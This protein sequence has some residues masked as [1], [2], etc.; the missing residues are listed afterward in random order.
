MDYYNKD[1]C[2]YLVTSKFEKK[3]EYVKD[4]INL[5]YKKVE[6]FIDEDD[7]DCNFLSR[8]FGYKCRF[9]RNPKQIQYLFETYTPIMM[10]KG[11]QKIRNKA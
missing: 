3:M 8:R 7:Q 2:R 9:V 6:S 11:N 1:F 10:R 5:M 4:S